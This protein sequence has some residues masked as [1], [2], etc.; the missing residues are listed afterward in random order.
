MASKIS[1]THPLL[2]ASGSPRRREILTRVGIPVVVQAVDVDESPREREDVDA[3]LAR[4][5]E[6][7]AA[8]ATAVAALR[9]LDAALVADTVV[10]H[11]GGMLGKPRDEAE[12][13]AM[14]NALAGN[15]HTVA[16]RYAL[17]TADGDGCV[18]TVRTRVW[19]RALGAAQIARYVATGEG[20]DKAGAYAIQ[21]IG[22]MLVE[23]VEGDYENVVGLPICSVVQAMERLGLITACPIG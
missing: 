4:I 18:E 7:K 11:E 6:D 1:Q 17:R 20:R 22:A 3:Y 13:Q 9:K 15:V 23:R 10:V 14:I 2:L 8:A 12:S 16:T 19:F 21:G 5:V